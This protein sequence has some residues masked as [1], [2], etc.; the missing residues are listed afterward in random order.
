MRRD[1]ASLAAQSF[2]VVVI[3]AGIHGAWIALRAARS[4]LKTALIERGDFGAATSANSLKVLHGGLRYLQHLDFKRM[5]ASIAARREYARSS[6]HLLQPTACVMPL[7]PGGVRSPW[8]FGPAL[9]MNDLISFDRNSGVP[10]GARLP[11]GRLLTARRCRAVTEQLTNVDAVAGGQWWDAVALDTERL[12]LEAVLA[13]SRSG[14]AIANRV[15]ACEYLVA[16]GRVA[17]VAARECV[18]GQEFE[19]RAQVTVNATGPWAAQLS[20]ASGLA[21]KVLPVHWLGALNLVLRRSLGIS[22]AVALSA[23]SRAAD[24]SSVLKRAQRELFFLPW[25]DVTMVGTDYHRVAD[26]LGEDAARPPAGSAAAFL[27]E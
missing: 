4:G 3:G 11:A 1:I 14:A 24:R 19:L 18:S 6:P 5:R 17:G 2:D 22:K 23:A 21:H 26:P 12:T 13:A 10:D 8:I 9:L 20:R 27:E 16:Q 7:A 25:C 15:E